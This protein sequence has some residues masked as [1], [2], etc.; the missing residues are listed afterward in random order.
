MRQGKERWLQR[1]TDELQF[2]AEVCHVDRI[3]GICELRWENITLLFLLI[4]N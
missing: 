2:T 3:Q 1:E 4:S